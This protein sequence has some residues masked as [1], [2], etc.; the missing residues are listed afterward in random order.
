MLTKKI[1][2]SLSALVA[3]LMSPLHALTVESYGLK[4]SGNYDAAGP[5]VSIANGWNAG[6]TDVTP[7]YLTL[8]CNPVDYQRTGYFYVGANLVKFNIDIGLTS[9]NRQESINVSKTFDS[10]IFKTS[11]GLVCY[12]NTGDVGF[13]TSVLLPFVF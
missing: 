10:Q 5:Y 12:L 6:A 11:L 9:L 13:E 3:L 7:V 1:I 2:I 4:Y 8:A